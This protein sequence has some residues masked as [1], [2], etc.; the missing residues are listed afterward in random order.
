MTQPAVAGSSP[1]AR[2]AARRAWRVHSL[3]LLPLA[4][5]ARSTSA[6]ISGCTRMVM[7]SEKRT[8]SVIRRPRDL[9]AALLHQLE[10]GAGLHVTVDAAATSPAASAPVRLVRWRSASALQER[11][12]SADNVPRRAP[13]PRPSY[14]KDRIPKLSDGAPFG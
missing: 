12:S 9:V 3:G 10:H 7:L 2:R 13:H 11:K 6:V 4:R 8:G 14:L 1:A 5:A